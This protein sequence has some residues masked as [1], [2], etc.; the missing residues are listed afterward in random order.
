MTTP[1]DITKT[2]KQL[3]IDSINTANNTVLLVN[4][5]TFSDPVGYTD[6]ARPLINTRVD[7][8]P[9]ATSPYYN[10]I[11]WKYARMDLGLV[12]GSQ[13]KVVLPGA[14][15]TV[16]DLI[17]AINLAF[18]INLT[19]DDYIDTP[20]PPSPNADPNSPRQVVIQAT[21]TSLLFVGAGSLTIGAFDIVIPSDDNVERLFYV[22]SNGYNGPKNSL[23]DLMKINGQRRE[24]WEFLGNVTDVLECTI[25]G[26]F[27]TT[28]GI[29]LNGTFKFTGA[30]DSDPT[31]TVYDV[32]SIVLNKDSGHVIKTWSTPKFDPTINSTISQNRDGYIYK[33]DN[34]AFLKKFDQN[35]D[36]V[37]GYTPAITYKPTSVT[38]DS[39]GRVYVSSP[40]FSA[41]HAW[42]NGNPTNQFKIDR[43]LADGSLDPAFS[44]VFVHA[45]NSVNVPSISAIRAI[46]TPTGPQ[47]FYIALLP[48]SASSTDAN[49]IVVINGTPLCPAGAPSTFAVNPI[50]KF[51]D[52]GVQDYSFKTMIQDMHP[53]GIYSYN[54]GISTGDKTLSVSQD[55]VAWLTVK[56]NPVT[57]YVHKQPLGFS[58]TGNLKLLGG[59]HYYSSYRWTNTKDV[60]PMSNGSLAMYG[61]Y[62]QRQPS[63]AWSNEALGV[64]LYNNSAVPENIIW[65]QQISVLGPV[66]ISNVL[67]REV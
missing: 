19:D 35:G 43:L 25:T 34:V 53:N 17:P 13:S 36:Q 27:H 12:F 7:I 47:G 14:A 45:T 20:V 4:Q 50:V 59:I 38:V 46:E 22:V 32:P 44:S 9:L 55:S 6:P 30:I 16:K 60:V 31:G 41:S 5:F 37:V 57:A 58:S 51:L 54:A 26:S 40:V 62:M 56:A 66:S 48:L 42:T 28:A 21:A 65:R 39:T 52:D 61:K 11:E 49:N 3:I 18:G 24:A 29:T 1:I 67:L 63:G 8:T 64:A 2:A 33:T 15:V 10:T 23:I